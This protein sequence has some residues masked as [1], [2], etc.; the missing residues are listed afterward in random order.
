MSNL[1]VVDYEPPQASRDGGAA[2]MVTLLQL[3]R[4][5]GHRVTFASLRPWPVDLVAT[6]RRLEDLGVGIAARDGRVEEWMSRHGPHFDVVI[7]S[8]LEVAQAM[9]PLARR[10]CP[11]CR[12]VYDAT[13]VEHLNK[14]RLAKHTG[15]R[16]VLSAALQDR[17]AES[18]VVAEADAVFVT[19][20]EDADA[21]R[22]LAAETEIHVITA[23][24]A[25]SDDTD[26][27]P[28]PRSGIVFL[29]YLGYRDNEFA[30]RRLVDRVWPLV[31]AE[32]GPTT[33]TV[34]GAAP[35]DWLVAAADERPGLKVAGHLPDVRP[36]LRSAA[37]MVVPLIGGS[38]VKT[39]VL[40][41]F[42]RMVP[43]V[44]T[45]DGLRGIP[46]VHGVHVLR[47]ESDAEL[48]A[49]VVEILRN[50]ARGREIATQAET[51]L[52]TQFNIEV[53]RKSLR[54]AMDSFV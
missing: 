1:L 10:H 27:A 23:V 18:E 8:R 17:S 33:L 37:V 42:A 22:A 45:A 4:D 43:V 14:F 16:A 29:G 31:Q 20:E 15:S 19:S 3:L 9:L 24:D 25:A 30:V 5:E 13:H 36:V 7:A 11:G 34:V 26:L 40:Q 6:A 44:A 48:A 49:A 39:K 52:R 28:G 35:P 50:P 51:L 12:F 32:L 53:S 41:S 54:K 21:L 46:A 38:G 2:R 47:G